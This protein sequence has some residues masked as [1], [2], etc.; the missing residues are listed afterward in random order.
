MKITVSTC[1]FTV[2][3]MNIEACQK[4]KFKSF[5]NIKNYLFLPL[6]INSLN[7]NK[8]EKNI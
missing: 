3:N 1:L 7:K 5:A 4:N 6:L 8:N 2:G